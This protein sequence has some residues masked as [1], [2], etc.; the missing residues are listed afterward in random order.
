MGHQHTSL[1]P[2]RPRSRK[3]SARISMSGARVAYVGPGLDLTPHRNAAATI[4]VALETPFTLEAPLGTEPRDTWIALIPPNTHHHLLASGAM[5]FVYLDALSDDHRHLQTL[6]LSASHTA[7]ARTAATPGW[8]V[9][10][11]CDALG[12]PARAPVDPR[13]AR[14]ARLLDA[15]PE[16]FTR[17]AELA[18]RV[19]LSPSR[20]Q[21]LFTEGVGLPFRRYRLWRRMALVARMVGDGQTLTEAAHGAGFSSSAHLS[22]AFREMFGLALSQLL[23]TEVQIEVR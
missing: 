13:V 10:A 5:A 15:S 22:A 3:P 4:A 18:S 2:S 14:A 1:T 20:F 6:D 11:L 21:A 8:G 9:E 16:A 19:G 12:V 17:V 7:V 23:S